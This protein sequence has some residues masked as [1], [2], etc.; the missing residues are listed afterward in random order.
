MNGKRLAI[1][2][3]ELDAMSVAMASLNKNK[4]IY[5]VVSLPSASGL[6]VL[7]E[8]RKW[9]R[10]FD[11]V[12]LWIDNDEAGENALAKAAKIIGYDKVRVV[13]SV[14]K[15]ASDVLMKK[16]ETEVN[17]C[18]WDAKPYSPC[19]LYTSPSPRD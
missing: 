4:T 17:R 14:E 16:G 13:R 10:S 8:Q 12:L 1:T 11:E 2:E 18:I 9:V 3:G 5:P 7:K 6:K 19:L 15:D